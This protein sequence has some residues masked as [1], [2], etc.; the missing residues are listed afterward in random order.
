MRT[1][2]VMSL[3]MTHEVSQ[4]NTE[5]FQVAR[6]FYGIGEPGTQN[7]TTINVSDYSPTAS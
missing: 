4:R 5:S 7:V 1:G 3:V 6:P 2:L